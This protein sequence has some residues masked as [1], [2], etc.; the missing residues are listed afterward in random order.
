MEQIPGQFYSFSIFSFDPSTGELLRR[1]KRVHIPE[2]SARLLSVLLQDAGLLVTRQQIRESLWPEGTFLDHDHAINK[3]ISL[4]RNILRENPRAAS[5]IET[6]PKRGYRLVAELTARPEAVLSPSPA[7]E[8]TPGGAEA[9]IPSSALTPVSL[10]EPMGPRLLFLTRRARR[11]ALAA[12]LLVLLGASYS[13]WYQHHRATVVAAAPLT[14]GIAPFEAEGQDA[15][16]I[17]ESLRMELT[18]SVARIPAVQV[19]AAHS[20]RTNK[21]DVDSIR[22][23]SRTL[24]LSDL[25]FGKFTRDGNRCWLQLELVHGQDATHLAT[26]EYSGTLDQLPQIRQQAQHD[27]F[28]HLQVQESP[29]A[30]AGNT[31]N[32]MAYRHYLHARYLIAQRTDDALR[33]A[34]DELNTTL[35][36]DPSYAKAYSA[37]ANAHVALA[38]HG[39]APF[40]ENYKAAQELTDKSLR[41][42]PNLPEAIALQGYIAFR[43]HWDLNRSQTLIRQ[44]IVLEPGDATFHIWYANL[45]ATKGLFNEAFQ[46][47]DLA[48]TADPFWPAVYVTRCFVSNAAH[49]DGRAL[50]AS[51]KLLQLMPDWPLALNTAAWSFWNSGEYEQAIAYWKQMAVLQHD[52]FRI[53][54][55]TRGLQAFRHGGVQEYAHLRLE[56]I[57]KNP[58]QLQVSNDF[59]PA[60]WYAYAGEDARALQELRSLVD[61]HD[62]ESLILNID[63]AF[64][65]LHHYPAYQDLVRRVGLPMPQNKSNG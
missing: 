50:D 52:N 64:D 19:R 24:D 9:E 12:S 59:V 4:L 46:Q 42:D 14:L 33:A 37:Q 38:E 40:E 51:R 35:A 56:A 27:L 3:A 21:Q 53:N 43:Y 54:L 49:D 45:L 16:Q 47:L 6:I 62:P 5:V 15:E 28:L 7:A 44:A 17:A 39:M 57:R 22:T 10:I 31:N 20:F 1:G 34:I 41:L 48:Q 60:E 63:S 25:I 18:D 36:L 32:S 55:E 30:T 8:E 29:A 11:L 2:Q 26:L 13:L 61:R 23:L 65:S 58:T